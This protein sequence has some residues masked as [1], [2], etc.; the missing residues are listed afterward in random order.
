MIDHG[1]AVRVFEPTKGPSALRLKYC[2]AKKVFINISLGVSVT[3]S[4]VQKYQ[5]NQ[6]KN[7]N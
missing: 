4:G 2:D 7:M 6:R 5:F 3:A 1:A